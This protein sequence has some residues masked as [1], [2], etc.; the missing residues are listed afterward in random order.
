MH[1][2]ILEQRFIEL[3]NHSQ[4]SVIQLASIQITVDIY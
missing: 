4:K 2:R 3:T 1:M